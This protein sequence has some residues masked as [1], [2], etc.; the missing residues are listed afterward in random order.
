MPRDDERPVIPLSL[1][2]LQWST[3]AENCLRNQGL[4]TLGELASKKISEILSWQNAGQKT[5]E[6]IQKTLST[7]GLALRQDRPL[8]NETN[9][10][11][12]NR[13]VELSNASH[14]IRVSLATPVHAFSWSRRAQAVLRTSGVVFLGDLATKS[15]DEIL[16]L[17]NA[18]RRTLTE[19]SGTLD[20][21]GLRI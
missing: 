5:L 16:Q 2:E 11:S 19:L 3:R 14:R 10:A 6:E 20:D 12:P 15:V 7:F 4:T 1:Y 9:A 13:S 8:S 21:F 17:H 18:G